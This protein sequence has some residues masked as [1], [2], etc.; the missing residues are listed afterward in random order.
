MRNV[1]LIVQIAI[2]VL[3]TI[4]IL[5]QAKGSGMGTAFGDSGSAF[6]SRRGVEKLLYR[7]TIILCALFLIS[8]ILNLLIK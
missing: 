5:L 1:I 8:S 2:S 4:C 6:R 7:G 3:L